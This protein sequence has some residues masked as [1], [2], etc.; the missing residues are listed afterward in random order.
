MKESS[1]PHQNYLLANMKLKCIIA[2]KETFVWLG[3]TSNAP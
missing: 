3:V 1:S 2:R